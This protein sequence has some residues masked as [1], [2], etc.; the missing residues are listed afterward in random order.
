M[1]SPATSVDEALESKYTRHCLRYLTLILLTLGAGVRLTVIMMK[2][3]KGA[4]PA[5]TD[6]VFKPINQS[7]VTRRSKLKLNPPYQKSNTGQK[8]LSYFRPKIWSSLSSDLKS[9]K[10]INS[11]KHM[12]K[13]IFFKNSQRKETDL[14]VL[15]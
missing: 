8:C 15:C 3:F 13:A 11:F 1:T 5:Y 14:Y 7:R 12:M 6:E 4:A 9:T 10:D 2:F